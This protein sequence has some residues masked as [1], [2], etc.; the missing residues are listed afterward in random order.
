MMPALLTDAEGFLERKRALGVEKALV[1]NATLTL[2]G[3]AV[4][5]LAL[6]Q[7]KQWNEFGY[8]L[9]ARSTGWSCPALASTRSAARRC[10][11]SCDAR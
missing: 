2:P 1:T 9:A 5:D 11:R 4:D 7:L 8:E 6:D 10:S 3:G